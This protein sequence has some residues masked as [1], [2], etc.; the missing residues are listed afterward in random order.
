[1]FIKG[2]PSDITNQELQNFFSKFGDL[3]TAFV[4]KDPQDIFCRGY[5][6][7]IY[8]TEEDANKL[9][10]KKNL[11]LN[12]QKIFCMPFKTKKEQVEQTIQKEEKK[13]FLNELDGS[14]YPQMG[15]NHN[16]D[17]YSSYDVRI[18]R[19][20]SKVSE[21]FW[22]QHQWIGFDNQRDQI[23]RSREEI[24]PFENTNVEESDTFVHLSKEEHKRITKVNYKPEGEGRGYTLEF[25]ENYE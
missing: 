20:R 13:N 2:L 21:S 14:N 24:G 11:K 12:E 25:L 17:N 16:E 4:I 9:L 6:Y 10:K 22:P 5:G 8:N 3:K 18:K 19:K 15:W 7:A 23:L 1:M